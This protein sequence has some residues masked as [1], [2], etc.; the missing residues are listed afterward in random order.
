MLAKYDILY[1]V[2]SQPP[3][4]HGELVMS[5]D[6]QFEIFQEQMKNHNSIMLG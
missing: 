1:P 2:L 5:T 6:Y 4:P 3:G